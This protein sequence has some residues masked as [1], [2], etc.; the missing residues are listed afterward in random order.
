MAKKR[1]K[2]IYVEI[3]NICNL[4]CSFCQKTLRA[5]KFMSAEEFGHII[6]AISPYT[7]YIYFHV[8]GE[9]LLHP[10]LDRFITMAKDAGLMVNITTNATLLRKKLHIFLENPVRQINISLHSGDD[11]DSINYEQ[12]VT[13]VFYCCDRLNEAVDTHISLRVWNMAEKGYLFGRNRISIRSHLHLNVDAEF[14]WPDIHNDY[15]EET[16][17]CHGLTDHIAILCDGTVVPCCLDGNGVT[18]L[19]NIFNDDISSILQSEKVNTI[20]NGFRKRTACE[21]LCR[22]C[23]FKNRF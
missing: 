7:D 14:V 6:N 18:V 5:P 3:T 2:K 4:S 10:E 19:G 15:Y 22:H 12:Y 17:Y 8:K 16:G 21:E 20:L 23:S 11:N 1:F 9:P 13:D